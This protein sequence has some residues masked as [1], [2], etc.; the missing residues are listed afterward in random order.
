MKKDTNLDNKIKPLPSEYLVQSNSNE[1]LSMFYINTT[2][3]VYVC[4]HIKR[5]TYKNKIIGSD[6]FP[7][8]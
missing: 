2:F 1:N 6:S 5:D 4:F 8:F 7:R 3:A